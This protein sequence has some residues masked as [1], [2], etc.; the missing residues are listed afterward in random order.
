MTIQAIL[1][2]IDGTLADSEPLHESNVIAVARD[3]GVALVQEDLHRFL[4]RT[5]AA[6]W[7]YLQAERG[8]MVSKQAWLEALHAHYAQLAVESLKP[9]A[10]ALTHLFLFASMGLRQAA[11]SNSTRQNVDVTLQTLKIEQLFEFSISASEVTKPKPDPEPY[12]RAALRLMTPPAQCLVI[13]DSPTGA[14]SAKAAGMR[15][16]A[17]PQLADLVFDQIDYITDDLAR[18]DW[19]KIIRRRRP[20]RQLL[21][22]SLA[23][24]LSPSMSEG[25]LPPNLMVPVD[26]DDHPANAPKS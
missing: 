23:A 4:G 12:L 3:H 7:D 13:E 9:R 6:L 24:G 26:S 22:R 2:D 11:V 1:W 10:G 18:A 17:W 20:P 16:M 5:N 19:C 21:A 25:D 8:L 15:V 14:R